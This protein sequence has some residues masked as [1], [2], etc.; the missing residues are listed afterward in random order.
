MEA[1]SYARQ[2]QGLDAV[3][4]YRRKFAGRL[5]QLRHRRE[6]EI[7][8]QYLY[9]HVFD[10][11]IGIGRFIGQL[12]NVLQ[13]DGVDLSPE[14]VAFVKATH[15]AARVE[16]CDLTRGIDRPDASFDC[17][18]CLRSLSAIQSL[19]FILGEMLRIARP[20]GNVLF[21]YGRMPQCTL[22]DGTV[23]VVDSEPLDQILTDVSALPVARV[24][25][26]SLL[27]RLKRW[28]LLSRA[29][30]TP[31]GEAVPSQLLLSVERALEPYWWQRQ[32]VVLRKPAV[33]AHMTR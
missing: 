11:T 12:P 2:F 25:I 19:Q 1:Q 31:V 28:R 16:T 32:I 21:D 7:L 3:A 10:C 9:G 5:D 26:D 27:V 22:I 23:G 4:S 8:S 15:P 30:S 17:V 6:V 13:Y 18:L 20:G 29:L 24:P 33:A 14:F